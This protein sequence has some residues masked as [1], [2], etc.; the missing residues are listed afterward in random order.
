MN[1]TDMIAKF[2]RECRPFY[3]VDLQDGRYSLCLQLDSLVNEFAPYCQEAFNAYAVANGGGKYLANDLYTYGSGH[4]W[5]A[6]FQEAFKDDPNI[7]RIVYDCEAGGFFCDC[8]D[9]GIIDDLG[10]R[11]KTICEDTERFT[12]IVAEGIRNAALR[13]AEEEA[14]MKTVKG[15]LMTRP[16]ATFDLMTPYGNIRITPDMSQKLLAGEMTTVIIGNTRY[17][18]FEL[19]DQPI[20]EQQTDLFDENLIRMKTDEAPEMEETQELTM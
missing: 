14:L 3:L 5:R 18:D 9:L 2:N 19:L 17:A 11:F 13:Q 4:D 7:G 1:T 6:A 10:R 20:I 16:E 15:Q 8:S 12:P